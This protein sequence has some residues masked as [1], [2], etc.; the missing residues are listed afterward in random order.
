MWF[1]VKYSLAVFLVNFI[2]DKRWYFIEKEILDKLFIESDSK[3]SW[4]S[5]KEGNFYLLIFYWFLLEFLYFFITHF[6]LRFTRHHLLLFTL[7]ASLVTIHSL[8]LQ[9]ITYS[10]YFHWWWPCLIADHLITDYESRTDQRWRKCMEHKNEKE[11]KWRT[12]GKVKNEREK[13]SKKRKS[14]IW[15][16]HTVANSSKSS[17][18]VHA[19]LEW[20][21]KKGSWFSDV[22]FGQFW[23]FLYK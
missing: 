14:W 2:N 13:R 11:R 3:I 10:F 16:I 18:T 9:L 5:H 12:K 23:W 22:C 4:L 6:C 1:W 8:F 20:S 17:D 19:S 15:D 21:N 7:L